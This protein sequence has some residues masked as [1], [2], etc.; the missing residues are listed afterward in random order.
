ME[1][2]RTIR[3][4]TG[5][6]TKILVMAAI[7]VFA[8]GPLTA[9]ALLLL[10]EL[11]EQVAAGAVDPEMASMILEIVPGIVAVAWLFVVLMGAIR[12]V[13]TAA[14]ID[15]PACLLVSTRLRNVVVGVV[16]AEILLFSLWVVPPALV[17]AGA[18]ASGAGTILPVL[19]AP[20]VVALVLVTAIP[21]GSSSASASV[22]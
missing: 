13:T 3:A 15:K 7:G 2:R 6:R 5:D 11:G 16:G 9:V 18:F 20:L 21:V 10:P 17:L 12:T 1:C 8:F 14:K 22:T 19:I 4:V